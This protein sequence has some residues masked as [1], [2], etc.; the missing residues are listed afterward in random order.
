MG[1]RLEEATIAEMQAAMEAGEI[2]S[3]QLVEMYLAR[4]AAYDKEGP[5]INSVL[6]ISPDAIA[7]AE[8]LDEERA[9]PV[10]VPGPRWL[11]TLL[12]WQWERKLPVRF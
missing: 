1:F 5:K 7:I 8:A 4:I 11:R 10:P 9:A 3:R 6:E 12:R 2:T